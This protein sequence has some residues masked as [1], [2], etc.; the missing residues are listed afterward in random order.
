[1]EICAETTTKPLFSLQLLSRRQKEDKTTSKGLIGH[2][3]LSLSALRWKV[4]MQQQQQ[5]LTQR[6]REAGGHCCLNKRNFAEKTKAGEMTRR[7]GSPGA[8]V[9]FHV[10]CGK[11]ISW[12]CYFLL[13]HILNGGCSLRAG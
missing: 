13:F 4:G 7:L 12:P 6:K 3:C 11:A 1:M 10:Y 2:S 5:L 8:S 9:C